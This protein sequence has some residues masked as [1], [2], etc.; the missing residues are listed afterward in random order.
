MAMTDRIDPNFGGL[1][2][3]AGVAGEWMAEGAG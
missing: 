3:A 1:E 2:Q